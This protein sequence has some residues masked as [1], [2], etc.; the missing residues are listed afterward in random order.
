MEKPK[1]KIVCQYCGKE[2]Y[3]TVFW[4]R[5]CNDSHRQMDYAKRKKEAE[6]PPKKSPSV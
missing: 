6:Q 5:Y 4:Q 3:S 1:F 2:F